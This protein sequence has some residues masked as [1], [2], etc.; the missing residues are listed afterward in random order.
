MISEPTL[1]RS[2]QSSGACDCRAAKRKTPEARQ[3]WIESSKALRKPRAPFCAEVFAQSREQAAMPRRGTK[4]DENLSNA[5]TVVRL[6]HRTARVSKRIRVSPWRAI[7][8]GADARQSRPGQAAS[9]PKAATQRTFVIPSP[10][11]AWTERACPKIQY[12]RPAVVTLSSVLE[13]DL[14]IS[15]E[16]VARRQTS[17]HQCGS[18]FAHY[19]KPWCCE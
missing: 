6:Q 5:A 19:N 13:Q 3:R 16:A 12:R 7:F 4:T 10:I 17:N 8:D 11:A 2:E 18:Q 14:E 15:G 1:E 9:V